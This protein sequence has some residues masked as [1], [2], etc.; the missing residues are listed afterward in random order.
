MR[1]TLDCKFHFALTLC[2]YVRV[3]QDGL[4]DTELTVLTVKCLMER[5]AFGK[6]WGCNSW[7]DLL[8]REEPKSRVS[9]HCD[10]SASLSYVQ[11]SPWPMLLGMG[12]MLLL[13]IFRLTHLLRPVLMY[14]HLIIVLFSID[15]LTSLLSFGLNFTDYIPRSISFECW[16]EHC[17]IVKAIFAVFLWQSMWPNSS[18]LHRHLFHSTSIVQTCYMPH[19]SNRPWSDTQIAFEEYKL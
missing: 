14:F 15:D 4:Y 6:F 10:V 2:R 17:F 19:P 13:L 18:S 3:M 16:S 7:H 12:S 9:I 1:S 11:Q 5:W 8:N